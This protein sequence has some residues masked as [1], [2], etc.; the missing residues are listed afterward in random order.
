M[1]MMEKVKKIW[2]DGELVDWDNAK[3]HILTHTLHYGCGVF[4]GI[5]CYNTIKGPAVFRLKD[6][7]DRLFNSAKLLKIKIACTK[8]QLISAVKETI[9]INKL[10]ACYIRPIIY[11]GYGVMGL[12]P[13]DAPV[14]T[15]VAVWPWGAYLGEEGLKKGINVNISPYKRYPGELNKAKICG[16]YYNSI[17][18]KI[19]A[20]ENG[21]DEAVMF[22]TNNIL[23]EGSGE[24][25]FIIKDDVVKTPRLGSILPGITRDTVIKI[26]KNIGYKAAEAD[27]YLEEFKDCDEAFFTG[28]AAELTPIR[29]I[30]EKVIGKGKRG[31]ITEKLQ[32]KFFDIVNGKDDY[33]LDWLDFV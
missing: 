18:A 1:I 13:K 28:T 33:Y 3:V 17:L 20:L 11:Y 5:R 23:A 21:Y 7:V 10:N 26:A 30:D 19:N 25:I 4:E 6:H 31:P 22:D 15:A 9:K 32:S 8:E 29:Q 2:M 14:N 24:N 16:N 27:I 12:D